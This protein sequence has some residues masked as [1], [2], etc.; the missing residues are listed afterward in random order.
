VFESPRQQSVG[1]REPIRARQD[2]RRGLIGRRHAL[3]TVSLVVGAIVERFARKANR[4]LERP[5]FDGANTAT[6]S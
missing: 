6:L 4:G 5:R 2:R 3:G 1:T